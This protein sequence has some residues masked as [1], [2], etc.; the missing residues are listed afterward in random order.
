MIFMIYNRYII[1]V[2]CL[3]LSD[4]LTFR[5]LDKLDFRIID[6]NFSVTVVP[7]LNVTLTG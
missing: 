2:L 6:A 3:S 5:N 1:Y 4:E 7:E